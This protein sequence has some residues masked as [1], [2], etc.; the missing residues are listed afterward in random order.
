[1]IKAA[2][3]DDG[4]SENLYHNWFLQKNTLRPL[5]INSS[6]R[7]THADSCYG[8]IKKYLLTPKLVQWHNIKILPDNAFRANIKSLLMALKLCTLLDVKVIHLSI[9]TRY[10]RDF[11]LISEEIKKQME[12]GAIIVAA[13]NNEGTITYPASLPQVI[14]VKYGKELSGDEF[15]Y[16]PNSYDGVQFIA[17]AKHELENYTTEPANSFAAPLITSKV[18]NLLCERPSSQFIDV[19]HYLCMLSKNKSSYVPTIPRISSVPENSIFFYL[20]K[21]EKYPFTQLKLANRAIKDF[22]K[23]TPNSWKS[24]PATSLASAVIYIDGPDFQLISEEI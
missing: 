19:M 10:W 9:G 21:N 14:G 8:V 23:I 11:Q 2:I 15:Y 20:Y 17:S 18:L 12:R 22:V 1:M 4:V 6:K 13:S 3:I 5:V 7:C 24:Y 16:C